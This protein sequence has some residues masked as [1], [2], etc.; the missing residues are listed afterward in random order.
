MTKKISGLNKVE[1]R[2]YLKTPKLLTNIETAIEYLQQI[3]KDYP[4]HLLQL[5]C[6]FNDGRHFIYYLDDE[7][8]DERIRREEWEIIFKPLKKLNTKK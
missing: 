8:N 2:F 6:N 5:G 1:R 3:K 4:N 7:T